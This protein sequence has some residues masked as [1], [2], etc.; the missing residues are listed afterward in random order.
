MTGYGADP[1]TPPAKSDS[2][3]S[4]LICMTG[5]SGSI[6]GVKLLEAAIGRFSP[7]YLVLS[8][9][10]REVMKIELGM[11]PGSGGDAAVRLLGERASDV[12]AY[13]PRTMQAPFASGSAAADAMVVAPCSMGTL[14]RIAS[15]VSDDL[16]TRAADVAMKERRKLILVPRETP[17]STLHL[18][19]MTALSEM[20]VIILPASPPFYHRPKTI[21]ELVGMVVDRI[22][23]HT[24]LARAGAYRWTETA[25]EEGVE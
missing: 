10:A 2:R 7:L 13:P 5:A 8:A 12:R 20:G 24:G 17:Y 19:Q 6:Y 21:D 22:L 15:G 25:T 18:R 9:R 16:I 4:L 1:S 3:P 23:A 14:S 11:D